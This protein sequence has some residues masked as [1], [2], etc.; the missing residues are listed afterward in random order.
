VQSLGG[1]QHLEVLGG[2]IKTAVIAS[3]VLQRTLARTS[4]RAYYSKEYCRIHKSLI[5]QLL[6]AHQFEYSRDF[7]GSLR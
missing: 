4:G 6:L 1:V 3:Q 7:T 5:D 2:V